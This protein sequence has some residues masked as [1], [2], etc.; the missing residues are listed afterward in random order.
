M[1]KRQS[2]ILLAAAAWTTYVWVSRL[3]IMAGQDESVGFKVVHVVLAAVSLA[4]GV[5][6]G[7][8]GWQHRSP[9]A[10]EREAA[11]RQKAGVR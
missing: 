5:A 7:R 10:A 2:R 3:I 8:I 11:G 1:T 4:F 6:V 9:R